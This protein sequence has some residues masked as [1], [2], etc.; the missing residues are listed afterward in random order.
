MTAEC[1]GPEVVAHRTFVFD[2]GKHVCD[3]SNAVLWREVTK[4]IEADLQDEIFLK[5]IQ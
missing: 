3:S 1:E 2:A 5:S 4:V